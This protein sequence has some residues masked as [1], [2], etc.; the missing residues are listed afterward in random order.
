MMLIVLMAAATVVVRRLNRDAKSAKLHD[1]TMLA[2]SIE[3]VL[4]STSALTIQW[5]Q[6]GRHGQNVD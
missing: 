2:L 4:S 5:R 1:M 6:N 3:L